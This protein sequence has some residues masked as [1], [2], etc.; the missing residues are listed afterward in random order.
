MLYLVTV[1]EKGGDKR[2]AEWIAE[3]PSW[4]AGG[5]GRVILDTMFTE[6]IDKF[7]HT[8]LLLWDKPAGATV[9]VGNFHP[10]KFH[11]DGTFTS[12]VSTVLVEYPI[13]NYDLGVL[14]NRTFPDVTTPLH[15]AL[16]DAVIE[17]LVNEGLTPEESVVLQIGL[18]EKIRVEV[19]QTILMIGARIGANVCEDYGYQDEKEGVMSATHLPEIKDGMTAEQ[20]WAVIEDILDSVKQAD[21]DEKVYETVASYVTNQYGE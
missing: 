8:Q 17:F 2:S 21:E 4:Q 5:Q 14:F 11:G 1:T 7:A 12:R 15:D 20:V 10:A 13:G 9:T 19:L 3:A 18:P 6:E 16:H